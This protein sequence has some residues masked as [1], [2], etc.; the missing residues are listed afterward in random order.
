MKLVFSY[1]GIDLTLS[2]LKKAE[3]G[4]LKAAERMPHTTR[5]DVRFVEDGPER[6]VE[7]V[8]TAPRGT[9]IV[10]SAAGRYWGP[11][12]SDALA[13]V[14]RQGAKARRAPKSRA[15]RKR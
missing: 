1:R 7:I 15:I 11:A 4:V 13:K 14:V 2:M 8:F 9:H 12:I 6:R 3:R 10:G 5:A